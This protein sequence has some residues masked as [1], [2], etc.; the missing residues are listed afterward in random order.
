MFAF[1]EGGT[2]RDLGRLRQHFLALFWLDL[3]IDSDK[4]TS[5]Q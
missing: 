3:R 1:S 5:Q 4:L 2:R